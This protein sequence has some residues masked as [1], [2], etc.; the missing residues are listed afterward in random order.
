MANQKAN[1]SDLPACMKIAA[2]SLC[3]TPPPLPSTHKE[4]LSHGVL[5][6][7]VVCLSDEDCKQ[8]KA[9]VTLLVAA[10]GAVKMCSM[11]CSAC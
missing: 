2:L 9:L 3:M 1:L 6:T 7:W 11:N 5:D 10:H 8:Q 4:A